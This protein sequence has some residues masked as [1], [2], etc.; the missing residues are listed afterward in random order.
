MLRILHNGSMYM[1][2]NTLHFQF[3]KDTGPHQR[4]AHGVSEIVTFQMKIYSVQF[5]HPF[6]ILTPPIPHSLNCYNSLRLYL[7]CSSSHRL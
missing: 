2:L 4:Q 5:I 7:D 3:A 1:F 6:Q